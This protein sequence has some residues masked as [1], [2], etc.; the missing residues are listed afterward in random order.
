[1]TKFILIM[2]ICSGIPGNECK[3]MPVP[4]S[5]F[6]DTY[7]ECAY[8]GYDYSSILLKEFSPDFVDQYKTFTAFS[9]NEEK[10]I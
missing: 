6:D 1:M 8:Y 9:C 3:L 2:F 10:T 7:H 5:Q 4:V